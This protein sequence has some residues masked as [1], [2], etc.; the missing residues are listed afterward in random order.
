[1]LIV[2]RRQ[3]SCFCIG[4]EEISSLSLISPFRYS[5][6][7]RRAA[8]HQYCFDSRFFISS[9][10]L[11]LRP[12]I[13]SFACSSL[14]QEAKVSSVSLMVLWISSSDSVFI[15]LEEMVDLVT[16]IFS[17][18]ALYMKLISSLGKLYFCIEFG[19]CGTMKFFA[20]CQIPH[21]S[22]VPRYSRR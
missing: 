10:V 3:S 7:L 6:L 5:A 2:S 9:G 22:C 1:M 20:S 14:T 4:L 19:I 12:A 18:I 13:V 17:N 21:F 11:G 15:G 8:I 16:L